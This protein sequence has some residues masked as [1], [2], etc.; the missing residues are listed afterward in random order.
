M[1]RGFALEEQL[2]V[3]IPA[4]D[5]QFDSFESKPKT[6][7]EG[8]GEGCL[9]CPPIPCK[10]GGGGHCREEEHTAGCVRSQLGSQSL[11]LVRS[12]S[13]GRIQCRPGV[14]EQQFGGPSG[15]RSSEVFGN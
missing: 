4:M 15:G 3:G 12:R 10:E 6:E 8:R 13:A 1:Q 5:L 9:W 11:P 7:Q 14:E 2:S